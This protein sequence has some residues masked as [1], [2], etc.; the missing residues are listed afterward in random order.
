MAVVAKALGQMWA[1]LSAEEKQVYQTQAAQERERVA[2]ELKAWQDAGGDASTTSSQSAATAAAAAATAPDHL[3]FPAA[4]IRKICKLDPDVRGLSKESVL[5]VAKAAELFAA[6]LG[7]ECV[8]VA[9]IQNR[10]KLLPDDVAQVC[11]SRE[12][13]GFLRDDIRDLIKQQVPSAAAGAKG[14]GSKN[15]P[16]G[17]ASSSKP[18]TAYFPVKS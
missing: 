10:R 16:A 11:A 4:R 2:K 1:T 9:Q 12:A 8:R 13:F 3:D 5:L 15:A 17:P 18:L 14:G 7:K 6:K